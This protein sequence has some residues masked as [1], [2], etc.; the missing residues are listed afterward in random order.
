VELRLRLL[1]PREETT[2]SVD[3]L[4]RARP[5]PIPEAV[6]LRLPVAGARAAGPGP[7]PLRTPGARS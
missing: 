1:V 4:R 7:A 5:G 6:V 3:L 2:R